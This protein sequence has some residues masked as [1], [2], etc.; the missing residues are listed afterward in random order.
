MSSSGSLAGALAA[1]PELLIC[2]E[3]TS[4]LDVSVQAAILDILGELRA[5]LGL[6]VAAAAPRLAD[7]R[8]PNAP[9]PRFNPP[10]NPKN[11]RRADGMPDLLS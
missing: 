2:D 1:G 11:M 5:V 6:A 10:K 7:G 9:R 8:R 4:A 3:I